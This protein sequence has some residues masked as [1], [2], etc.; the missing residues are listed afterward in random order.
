MSEVALLVAS[1]AAGAGQISAGMSA[2]RAA[3]TQAS[4]QEEQARIAKDEAD[5]QAEQKVSE[6]GKFLA[7]QRMAYLA[8]GVSLAGTPGIVQAD[9]F[10]EFQQEIE[11]IRKSGVA[12]FG[13]GMRE[14]ANTRSSGR[15][16]LLAGFMQ[17]IGTM[18]TG[19]SKSG[20][21]S[22]TPSGTGGL[23]WTDT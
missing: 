13:L 8:N 6:R 12:Q 2:N 10:K 14:A 15:A 3:K 19:L 18:G 7:E 17:G 21:F 16:Q 11:A 22:K 5:R 20:I 9:T 1:V 4:L 23:S